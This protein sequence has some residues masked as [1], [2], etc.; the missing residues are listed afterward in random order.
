MP[1]NT[2]RLALEREINRLRFEQAIA[3]EDDQQAH[4]AL[5]AAQSQLQQ[6]Q[7]Q[8]APL[9]TQINRLSRHFWVAKATLAAH[10]YDLSASR[11]RQVERDEEFYE[12]PGVT[13][14]RLLELER[15]IRHEV[16]ELQVTTSTK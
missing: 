5:D 7:R 8:I 13:L 4:A 1:L 12:E 10:K 3:A 15:I 2:Q 14:E 9:Q 16:I 11:Y 6:L